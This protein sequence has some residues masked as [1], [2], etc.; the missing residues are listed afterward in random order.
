MRNAV[1]RNADK[2][3]GLLIVYSVVMFFVEIEIRGIDTPSSG[4]FLWNERVVACIFT[5]EYFVRWFNNRKYPSTAHS[6]IDLA[7][8]L[9]F[10]IGFFVPIQDLKWVRVLRMLRLLKFHRYNGALKHLA[11]ACKG[12]KEELKLLGFIS[13][14]IIV[15]FSIIVFEIERDVKDT[16]FT[17]LSD[18]VWWTVVTLTTIGYGDVYPLT[19]LGRIFAC[20]LMFFGVGIFGTFISLMGS[21]LVTIFREERIAK[22]KEALC[23]KD[24]LTKS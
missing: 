13:I 15:A 4:F 14:T 9:P 16:K 1:F 23:T 21:S 6:F 17:K 3:I 20:L 11:N 7:G 8:F 22:E 24:S 5:I 19:T 18:S 10:W 12:V 2:I